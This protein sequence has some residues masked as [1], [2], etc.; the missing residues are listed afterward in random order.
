MPNTAGNRIFSSRW[1]WHWWR[2]FGRQTTGRRST[3]N[4]RWRLLNC[5]SNDFVNLNL[6]VIAG[7]VMYQRC[8][9]HV[10]VAAVIANL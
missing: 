9:P 1:R 4:L 10:L 3:C 2:I 8:W 6:R 7:T 5:R